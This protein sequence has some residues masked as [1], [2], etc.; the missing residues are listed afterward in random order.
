MF[1][2]SRDEVVRIAVAI[3][4]FSVLLALLVSSNTMA[5]GTSY[6]FYDYLPDFFMYWV[7]T[8]IS[9]SV[10]AIP[11]HVIV[12]KKQISRLSYGQAGISSGFLIG[13]IVSLGLGALA[14]TLADAWVIGVIAGGIGGPIFGYACADAFYVFVVDKRPREIARTIFWWLLGTLM[15]STPGIIPCLTYV[16]R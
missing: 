13:I 2:I 3:L 16:P 5:D 9:F 8:I 15:M 6:C 10:A 7:V 4:F 11:Y 1:D 14:G 12:R